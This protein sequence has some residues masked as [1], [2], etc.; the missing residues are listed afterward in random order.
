MA[1]LPKD[2][3]IDSL[4][5]LFVKFTR[6]VKRLNDVNDTSH[7]TEQ[8]ATASTEMAT[9]AVGLQDMVRELKA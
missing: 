7:G 3:S 5:F 1:E 9:L 4:V 6:L 2:Q 8:I